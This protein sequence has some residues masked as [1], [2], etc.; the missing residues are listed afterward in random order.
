MKV[1]EPGAPEVM[2][3]GD[4][5]LPKLSSRQVLINVRATALNRADT[6]QRK[7]LYPPPPGASEILGLEAAGVIE[8]LGILLSLLS[9]LDS[10]TP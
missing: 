5:E 8:E 2:S 9:Q 10:S 4:A 1:R 3:I 6:L 7:G